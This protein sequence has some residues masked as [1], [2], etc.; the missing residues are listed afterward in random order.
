LRNPGARLSWGLLA[1]FSTIYFVTA[2]L[3]SAEFSELAATTVLGLPLGFILGMVVIISGLVIT[4][5][6]LMRGEG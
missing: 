6:Y 2:I 4:R 5:I 3:T 1:I